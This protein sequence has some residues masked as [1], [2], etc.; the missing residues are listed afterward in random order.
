M[1]AAYR[2]G[3][4]RARAVSVAALV[5]GVTLAA[6]SGVWLMA[7]PHSVVVL[8]PG[9]VREIHEGGDFYYPTLTR[10][11]R[12]IGPWPDDGRASACAASQGFEVCVY[13]EFGDAF[14]REV[15]TEYR[16]QAQLLRGLDDF[17]TRAR[18]VPRHWGVDSCTSEEVLLYE[19]RDPPLIQAY[20][21]SLF[22]CVWAGVSH[23][24]EEARGAVTTWLFAEAHPDRR[25]DIKSGRM[26]F[27]S[28]RSTRA[29]LAMAN[30]SPQDV[31]ALLSP[32]W[33]ELR[34]GTLPL[35]ALP[36][37]AE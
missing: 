8:G 11:A 5:V 4:R 18:M 34:R 15:A 30:L 12:E 2:A 20:D 28:P 27:G 33:D 24:G 29:G 3:A 22:Q 16:Q 35:A 17:P 7:Q 23:E 21:S 25:A 13:P 9:T 6:S 10:L 36:G 37:G 32:L 19:S 14:A 1:I 26:G 31:R